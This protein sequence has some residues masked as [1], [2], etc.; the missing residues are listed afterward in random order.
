MKIG[1]RES[2]IAKHLSCGGRYPDLCVGYAEVDDA[3][4]QHARLGL[5]LKSR[6]VEHAMEKDFFSVYRTEHTRV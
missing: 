2:A 6:D 5:D 1:N 4:C 3:T